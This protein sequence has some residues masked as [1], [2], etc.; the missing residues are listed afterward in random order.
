MTQGGPFSPTIFNVMVDAIVREW[1]RQTLGDEAVIA[2]II[3]EIRTF[4]AAF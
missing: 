4:L 3:E 2:G 1:L